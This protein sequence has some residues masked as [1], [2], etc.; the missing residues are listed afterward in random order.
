MLGDVKVVRMMPPQATP[1]TRMGDLREK[2]VGQRIVVEGRVVEVW[3]FSQGTK[4]LLDDGSGRL[5]LLLWQSVLDDFPGRDCLTLDTTVRAA[6]RVSAYQGALEL[7]P[8]VGRDV[9]CL[10]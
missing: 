8:G 7:A 4:Y 6:G 3:P 10:P 9:V 1:P 2:H 5:T